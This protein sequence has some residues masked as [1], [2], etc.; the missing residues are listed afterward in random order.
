MKTDVMDNDFNTIIGIKSEV[1]RVKEQD[2]NK[3]LKNPN[4]PSSE[5][6]SIFRDQRDQTLG[7][8]SKIASENDLKSASLNGILVVSINE[9]TSNI[10]S[11]PSDDYINNPKLALTLRKTYNLTS[12]CLVDSI[13][14]EYFIMEENSSSWSRLPFSELRSSGSNSDLKA[15]ASILGSGSR[16]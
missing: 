6:A 8:L 1:H 5:L 7:L 2:I 10:S 13:A 3:V 4:T 16:R 9:A 15:L 12:M 14:E 11:K